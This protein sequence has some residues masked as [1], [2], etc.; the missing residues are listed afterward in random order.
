MDATALQAYL[1]Q[2][3]DEPV[4][5][6]LEGG[7]QS[8]E[9]FQQFST[10]H[11]ADLY[12][13][14]LHP[15]LHEA[16]D[17]G[18]W[19][20]VIRSPSLLKKYMD[21]LSGIVGVIISASRPG[22]LAVQ[23]SS[24][25]TVIRPDGKTALLRFYN[26]HVMTLLAGCRE[27]EWQT[28]LF[29]KITQW[30]IAVEEE[31]VPLSLPEQSEKPARDSTI[32]LNASQWRKITDS[33]EVTSVLKQW[34]RYPDSQYFP[35]CAQRDMVIKALG[36]ARDSGMPPGADKK[37]YSLVYLNGNKKML[38][39]EPVFSQLEH[40]RRGEISLSQLLMKYKNQ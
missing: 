33:T 27:T 21:E 28:L 31:W 10:T 9:E 5:L 22:A 14:Y 20:F 29:N 4:Y 1:S 12:S 37:L 34:Q 13:L 30:W 38:E 24:A 7:A 11:S 36:K 6:L 26:H 39:S 8:A 3:A 19:L 2:R 18:P 40:V 15:Q 23:L 25:C 35:V 16:R 17:Y 32:R